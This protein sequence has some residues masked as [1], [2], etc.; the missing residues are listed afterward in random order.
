M[1]ILA[2]GVIGL[3]A[4]CAPHPQQSANGRTGV[5]GQNGEI[6]W[7]EP[8]VMLYGKPVQ[9]VTGYYHRT[10]LDDVNDSIQE[11][12][13]QQEQ[14]ASDAEDRA[15]EAEEREQ[16]AALDRANQ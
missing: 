4:G 3:L 5:V 1:K 2:I 15:M 10:T 7:D 8:G 14:A 12:K 6:I 9:P 16:Q 13:D 11:L